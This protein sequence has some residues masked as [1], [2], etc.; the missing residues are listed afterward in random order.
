MPSH[1]WDAYAREIGTNIQRHRAA[2]GFSQDRVAYEAN[3]SRYTYQK[4]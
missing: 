4:L 2:R 3:L 1:D